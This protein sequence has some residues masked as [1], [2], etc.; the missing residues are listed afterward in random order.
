MTAIAT[1]LISSPVFASADGHHDL[2]HDLLMHIG[3]TILIATVLAYVGHVAEQPLIIT[4]ITQ[5]AISAGLGILF[6]QL[7]GF[8]LGGGKYDAFY[9]AVCCGISSTAIVVLGV[10]PN[11]A[12]P[13]ILQ[14]LLSFAKAG[15]LVA[16]SVAMSKYVLPALFSRIA[17]IPELTLLMPVGLV[18]CSLRGST[19]FWPVARDGSAD[20]GRFYFDFSL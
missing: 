18:L 7:I 15:V 12:N 5:F 6:F 19:R 17:K 9:L 4:G 16:I 11:L 3:L 10:Q 8:A 2:V 20:C 1:L 13:E 14:I